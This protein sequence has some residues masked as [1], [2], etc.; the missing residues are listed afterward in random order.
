[1]T[2]MNDGE[3][4]EANDGEVTETN[5]GEVT[6]A[7]NGE[8]TELDEERTVD[9][10]EEQNDEVTMDIHQLVRLPYF[11]LYL[12]YLF[13]SSAIQNDA[14]VL[15]EHRNKKAKHKIPS[16]D[17]LEHHKL[18][19]Q[20]DESAQLAMKQGNKKRSASNN[21]SQREREEFRQGSD[22]GGWHKEPT[23]KAKFNAP[24]YAQPAASKSHASSSGGSKSRSR[25]SGTQQSGT[26]SRLPM[27]DRHTSIQNPNG[28]NPKVHSDEHASAHYHGAVPTGSKVCIIQR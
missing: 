26:H 7:N 6:E 23:K 19:L 2:E 8:A 3:V 27:V 24:S 1:M 12:Q 18:S 14:S 11:L 21:G 13:G 15:T 10:G 5:D 16:V 9:D 22:F 4:T 20:S 17:D 28:S 25:P